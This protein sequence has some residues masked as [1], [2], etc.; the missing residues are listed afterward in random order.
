MLH[1]FFL[2]LSLNGNNINSKVRTDHTTN[3]TSGTLIAI[4]HSNRMIPLAINLSGF[5]ENMFRAKL[6]TEATPLT[7]LG[8]HNNLSF[9]LLQITLRLR[10]MLTFGILPN[11]PGGMSQSNIHLSPPASSASVLKALIKQE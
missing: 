1:R 11:I 7:P 5:V 10:S 8:Y 6:N 2:R 3:I 9:S 4:I